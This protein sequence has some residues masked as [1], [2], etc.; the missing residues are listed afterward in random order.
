MEKREQREPWGDRTEYIRGVY[1]PTPERVL[2]RAADL[3]W[4]E[5][6]GFDEILI[7][8]VMDFDMPIIEVVRRLVERC[9]TFLTRQML[10]PFLVKGEYCG[11]GTIPEA[12]EE[13]R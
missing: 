10:D 11:I 13:G 7:G 4:L 2:E 8:S 3:R 9:G 6:M 1:M 5:E 12:E